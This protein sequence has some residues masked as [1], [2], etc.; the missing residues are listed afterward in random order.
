MRP[1]AS[2]SF[3]HAVDP[4]ILF[5][6]LDAK[7]VVGTTTVALNTA[8]ILARQNK[9][10]IALELRSY[11]NSF[12][13]QTQQSPSRTLKN[14]LD[15]EPERI[16]PAEVKRCLVTLPF[17]VR[18]LYAP[19]KPDDFMEILPGHADAIIRC[20]QQMADFVV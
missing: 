20:A 18:A 2:V 19:Q 14:L 12:S 15:L 7:G 5:G 4:S 8:A 9:P 16:T 3:R 6:V 13:C 11:S 1:T 10:V 17:G